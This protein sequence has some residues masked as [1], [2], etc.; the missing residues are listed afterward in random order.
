MKITRFSQIPTQQ[1]SQNQANQGQQAKQDQQVDKEI[2]EAYQKIVSAIGIMNEAL[3]T[4]E[5]SGA[6]SMFKKESLIEE[7]QSG[8]IADFDVN[9]ADN[10]LEAMRRITQ[11][12]QMLNSALYFLKQNENSSSK[13]SIDIRAIVNSIVSDL[14]AGSYSHLVSGMEFIK[15]TL[16]ESSGTINP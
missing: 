8:R 9:K 11:A 3:Q 7:I 10:A 6:S 5:D 1:G 2:Q 16:T 15:Q 4:I 14:N 12:S 13:Y